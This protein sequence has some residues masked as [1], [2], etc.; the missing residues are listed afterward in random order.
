MQYPFSMYQ[1]CQSIADG[2]FWQPLSEV[3]A[4]KQDEPAAGIR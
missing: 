1:F 4:M 3:D 2:Y